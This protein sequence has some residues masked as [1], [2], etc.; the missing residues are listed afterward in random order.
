MENFI[1]RATRVLCM[2]I[3]LDNLYDTICKDST[4]YGDVCVIPSLVVLYIHSIVEL[5]PKKKNNK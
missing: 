1:H 2:L 4:T 5:D 3:G